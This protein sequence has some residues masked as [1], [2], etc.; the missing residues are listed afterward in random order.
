MAKSQTMR[1][2]A[3][4]I[5]VKTDTRGTK[6]GLIVTQAGLVL[7]DTPLIPREARA[8]RQEMESLTGKS[9]AYIINTDHH[10]GHALGNAFFDAITIAHYVAWKHMRGYG[11]NFR[12]R[13]SD[14]YRDKDPETAHE[15]LNLDI[16]LPELTFLDR[17]TLFMGDKTIEA[18]NLGGHTPASSVVYIPKERVVFTGDLV[19]CNMHP[20]MA[21]GHAG[22]WIE[23]LTT[24]KQMPIDILV[25]GHGEVCGK[26]ALD[27]LLDYLK[28][29]REL[30]RQE[31]LAG[32]SKSEAARSVLP[33]IIGFF[34]RKPTT[35]VKLEA[36]I[37]SG[38]GHVY[39]EI[40]KEIESQEEAERAG[41]IA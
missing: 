18:I 20:F 6:L 27:P 4:D 38:L 17:L 23:A 22:Q 14:R 28:V 3:P 32:K 35:G 30:V 37:K 10:K 13:L 16:Q 41:K 7:V 21:Q 34:P 31:Y 1:Q 2:I 39:D 26:E 5:Y 25:P 29:A 19:V 12:Q 11:D 40:R 9:P 8:W 36:K 33:K 24:L 15:L